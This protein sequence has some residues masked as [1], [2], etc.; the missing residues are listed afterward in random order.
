MTSRVL[1]SR[2]KACM[3]HRNEWHLAVFVVVSHWKKSSGFYF[4]YPRASTSFTQ[5][6]LHP[7]PKSAKVLRMEIQL[8]KKDRLN[9]SFVWTTWRAQLFRCNANKFVT[10]WKGSHRLLIF[11]VLL[12]SLY[13]SLSISPSLSL[14]PSLSLSLPLSIS[15]SISVPPS[16]SICLYLSVSLYFP[17]SRCTT[18]MYALM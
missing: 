2:R 13:L 6:L 15:P 17:F 16:L 1:S 5:G 18:L 4:V 14:P 9:R 3:T 8:W 7:V 10:L 11:K 12:G